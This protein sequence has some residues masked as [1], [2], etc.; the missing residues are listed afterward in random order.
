MEEIGINSSCLEVLGGYLH[1]IVLFQDMKQ[2]LFVRRLL[3]WEMGEFLQIK[4]S[5]TVILLVGVFMV[6]I[7]QKWCSY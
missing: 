6:K 2:N 3:D 4:I 5:I 1:F 7:H